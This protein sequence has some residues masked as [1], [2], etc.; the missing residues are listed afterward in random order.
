MSA[1]I[2]G[3]TG[4]TRTRTVV[5]RFAISAPITNVNDYQVRIEIGNVLTIGQI[6]S[7]SGSPSFTPLAGGAVAI[8]TYPWATPLPGFY[9]TSGTVISWV[10]HGT[11]TISVPVR[12]RLS[13]VAVGARLEIRAVEEITGDGTVSVDWNG[14]GSTTWSASM[15]VPPTTIAEA[16]KIATDTGTSVTATV[17]TVIDGDGNSGDPYTWSGSFG[18]SFPVFLTGSTGNPRSL[19]RSGGP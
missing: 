4:R 16:I 12:Q 14:T 13:L 9:S 2:S 10:S 7:N 8:G 15:G 6:A 17:E 5:I 1:F 3:L 11:V 19:T 18:G